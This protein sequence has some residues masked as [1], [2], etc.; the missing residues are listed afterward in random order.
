[1]KTNPS[2]FKKKILIVDDHSVVR[3]GIAGL[4]ESQPDLEVTLQLKTAEQ[5]LEILDTVAADLM[6]VDISLPGMNG[7]ELVKNVIFQK[8][9]QKILILSRHEESTYAER[10]LRAGARGYVMKFEASEMLLNAVRKVLKGGL[11]ISEEISEKLLLSALQGK[12]DVLSSPVEILSDRELEVFELIGNGMSTAEI[13][14]QLHLA[15]KTIET[16]RS[17]IKDKLNYK[18]STELMFNAV[19]WVESEF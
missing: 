18:N 8:P 4:V 7:I 1:M 15:Q 11:Y 10:A 17:R 12:K 3:K 2:I 5:L 9:D 19:K 6:I 14:E 16:Y 13:A